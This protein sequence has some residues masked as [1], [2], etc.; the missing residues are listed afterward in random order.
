[1]VE[2]VAQGCLFKAKRYI[3]SK[4]NLIVDRYSN[5][6]RT[7]RLFLHF[8]YLSIRIQKHAK[9]TRSASYEWTLST[10]ARSWTNEILSEYWKKDKN[11]DQH[12]YYYPYRSR[13]DMSILINWSLHILEVNNWKTFGECI[14]SIINEL[15]G[16][17]LL[18]VN[19]KILTKRVTWTVFWIPT[20]HLFVWR[21][22]RYK[23][24]PKT[25]CT[26][27][28]EVWKK[29]QWRYTKLWCVR[30]TN[31]NWIPKKRDKYSNRKIGEPRTSHSTMDNE[32]VNPVSI[33]IPI[34]IDIGN[35]YFCVRLRT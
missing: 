18:R 32:N 10:I 23:D 13:P 26:C 15:A 28:F 25:V 9:R 1:M 21:I 20:E 31:V 34:R 30:G 7:N 29:S 17:V 24:D 2:I 4:S 3:E 33:W 6:T 27:T 12:K 22:F 5:A 35:R 11:Y 14:Q 16:I 19:P 8:A